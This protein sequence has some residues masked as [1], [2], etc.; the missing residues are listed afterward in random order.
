[1]SIALQTGEFLLGRGLHVSAGL[2]C[3]GGECKMHPVR[4]SITAFISFIKG[5]GGGGEGG[6]GDYRC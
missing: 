6:E 2:P 4:T 1:M 3:K 5:E